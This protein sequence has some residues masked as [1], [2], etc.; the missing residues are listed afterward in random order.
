MDA[1]NQPPHYTHADIEA[2]DA[3]RA[4]LG[5][6][7]FK[8]FCRGNALKYLWRAAHKGAEARDIDKGIWYMRMSN[9]DDP[10]EDKRPADGYDIAADERPSYRAFIIADPIKMGL[11]GELT[12]QL[13]YGRYRPAYDQWYVK[14]DRYEFYIHREDCRA[15]HALPQFTFT[16]VEEEP[17]LVKQ[18]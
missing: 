8:A 5:D 15:G 9:G 14:N 7:G 11:G 16:D 6:G 18:K 17:S 2:I 4:A 12:D 13:V 3:I 10:R 1:V